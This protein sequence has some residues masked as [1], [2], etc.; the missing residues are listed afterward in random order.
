MDGIGTQDVDDGHTTL[1]SPYYDFSSDYGISDVKPMKSYYA[2]YP[3]NAP[4][5]KIAYMFV[6]R[7]FDTRICKV[8]KNFSLKLF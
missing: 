5:E 7:R 2:F 6:K 1:F 4:L 3:K 8:K